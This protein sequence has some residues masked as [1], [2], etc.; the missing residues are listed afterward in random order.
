[1]QTTKRVT[2]IKANGETSVLLPDKKPDLKQ[3]QTWVGGLI[4]PMHIRYNGKAATMVVNE[5][6]LLESLEMN[7]VASRIAGQ[8]VVGDVFILEGWRL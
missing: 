5:E 3:M 6:G 7:L 2:I 1:M 8:V 4:E